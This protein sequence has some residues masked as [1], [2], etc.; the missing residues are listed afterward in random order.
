[1]FSFSD[2]ATVLFDHITEAKL[3]YREEY[4]STWILYVT[5]DNCIQ[6]DTVER[7]SF[8]NLV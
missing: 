4:I 1:M 6:D 7:H 8:T 5:E 3:I 2:V